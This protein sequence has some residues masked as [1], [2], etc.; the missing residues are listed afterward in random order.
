MEIGRINLTPVLP[1]ATPH[2]P[3]KIK[4]GKM[5]LKNIYG[6]VIFA[7]EGAKTILEVVMAARKA[8]KFLCGANLRGADLYGADLRGANLCG[9]NLC[10]ANLCGANLCGANLCGANLCGAD[11][12]GANL[13][14]ANLCG[15]NLCGAELYGADLYG[16]D[17]RGADLYG[18]NLRGKKISSLRSFSGLYRYEVWAVV[19]V[20]GERWIRMGCYFKSLEDWEKI[21]IRSS[22]PDEFP[23]ECE[24]RVAAFEFAKAFLARIPAVSPATPSSL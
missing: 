8:G 23:E 18:A 6:D 15:A 3:P 17:L 13:C 10:G 11:L 12:Y 21:G 2:V 4:E 5:E 16:A 7:L 1:V 24:E 9:A 20:S 19:F 22:N 14:G